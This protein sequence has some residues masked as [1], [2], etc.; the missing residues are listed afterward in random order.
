MTSNF[1]NM[2]YSFLVVLAVV[3]MGDHVNFLAW[4]Y[5]PLIMAVE[6]LLALGCTLITSALTVYFRDLQYFLGIVAMAWQFLTPVMYSVDM[7][8]DELM[9][10]FLINPMT[11]IIIA[12]RDVLYY[13]RI[14]AVETM[15]LPLALSLIVLVLGEL[16]FR[17]LQRNFA[18][19][20]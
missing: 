5:L 11:S 1:I 7:V 19:E 4:L 17:R 14:P 8:P 10:F 12:Y 9:P 20:L 3:L 18:E 15:V 16:I 13:G 2:L 6:Y